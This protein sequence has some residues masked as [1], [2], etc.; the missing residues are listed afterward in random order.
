MAALR[1]GEPKEWADADSPTQ[2]I[3]QLSQVGIFAKAKQWLAKE[4]AGD[5]DV[6]VRCRASAAADHKS[7]KSVV[8][9]ETKGLV[10][11]HPNIHILGRPSLFATNAPWH[12]SQFCICC[13]WRGSTCVNWMTA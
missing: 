3:S 2:K 6:Q 13:A 5:Y 4:L 9:S 7:K 11:K 1:R 8:A 10:N 12:F